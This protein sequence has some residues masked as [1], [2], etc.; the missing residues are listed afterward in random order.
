MKSGYAKFETFP[1][2]NL[3]LK[4]PV[5]VAYEAA[6]ADIKDFNLIDPFTWKPTP[7]SR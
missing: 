6:T 2:W 5:N 4:H 3:P 7:R 1:I